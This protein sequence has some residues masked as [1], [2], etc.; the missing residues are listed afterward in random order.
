MEE[1]CICEEVWEVFENDF[2]MDYFYLRY[3]GCIDKYGFL[4]VKKLGFVICV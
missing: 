3:L 4:Y 1:L 2:E